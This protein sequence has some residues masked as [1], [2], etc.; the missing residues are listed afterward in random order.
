MYTASRAT[1]ERTTSDASSIIG[2]ILQ[3]PPKPGPEEIR[4]ITLYRLPQVL[5]RLGISRS[6]WYAGIN[7]GRFPPGHSL[8]PRLRVWRSDE[9][10]LVISRLITV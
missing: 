4:S 6:T 7:S 1:R 9:I 10:D 2:S 3:T 5:S 8:S